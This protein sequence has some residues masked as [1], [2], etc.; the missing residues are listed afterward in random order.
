MKGKS[1]FSDE[2]RKAIAEGEITRYRLWKLT[3]IA[4]ATLSRFMTGKGGL[5]TEGLDK[6]AEVL[7]LAVMVKKP[8]AKKGGKH[9]KH[10]TRSGRA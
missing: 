4:E 2:I 10:R 6:I 1:K 7:G 9:G 5:S 8:Q 3:G